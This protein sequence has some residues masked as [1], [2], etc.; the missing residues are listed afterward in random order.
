MQRITREWKSERLPKGSIQRGVTIDVCAA[1]MVR[2]LR[3][4]CPNLHM[5]KKIPSIKYLFTQKVRY[6]LQLYNVRGKEY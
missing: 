1:R 3:L 6:I 2:N 5:G 4:T